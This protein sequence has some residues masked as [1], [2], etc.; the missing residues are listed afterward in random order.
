MVKRGEIPQGMTM[1]DADKVYKG[2][3]QVFIGNEG[4]VESVGV[5][6]VI[7]G[8]TLPEEEMTYCNFD[9]AYVCPTC[10]GHCTYKDDDECIW[11]AD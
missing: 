11:P 7:C 4:V 5:E 10:C 3:K 8:I 2:E 6:C 1:E 9:E